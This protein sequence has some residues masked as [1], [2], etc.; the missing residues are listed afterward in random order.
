MVRHFDV[1]LQMKDATLRF[2]AV[3][4]QTT[5]WLNVSAVQSTLSH[6]TKWVFCAMAVGLYTSLSDEAPYLTLTS[7]L[8][9]D[10]AKTRQI[11]P[12]RISRTKSPSRTKQ[13]TFWY[14]CVTAPDTKHPLCRW[15]LIFSPPFAE[16]MFHMT[17]L[18]AN[19]HLMS[20]L[21][22][23]Y[24]RFSFLSSYRWTVFQTAQSHVQW[25]R[26]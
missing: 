16:L 7:V 25:T 20:R 3:V 13:K 22:S 5:L 8:A 10:G 26:Q 15:C 18:N 12:A 21:Y 11:P 19:V 4:T 14:S 17:A 9:V 1:F 2:S 24:V 6:N 23:I